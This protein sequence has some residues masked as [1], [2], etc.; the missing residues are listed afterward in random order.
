M[1]PVR[2]NLCSSGVSKCTQISCSLLAG[3]QFAVVLASTVTLA[4]IVLTVICVMV[5]AKQSFYV[6]PTSIAANLQG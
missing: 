2:L 4:Q 5:V 6:A 1:P 3:W